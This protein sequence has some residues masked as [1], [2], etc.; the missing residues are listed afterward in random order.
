MTTDQQ[1]PRVEASKNSAH[2]DEIRILR[3]E[4]AGLRMRC[5]E[6]AERVAELEAQLTSTQ[7]E[8][9]DSWDLIRQMRR[10]MSWRAGRP[11]RAARRWLAS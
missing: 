8:L 6:R 2:D 9:A 4:L 11:L 10:S 7:A 3:A 1:T 5:S